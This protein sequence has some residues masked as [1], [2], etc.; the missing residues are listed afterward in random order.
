M[1][2]TIEDKISQVTKKLT[3]CLTNDQKEKSVF[4]VSTSENVVYNIVIIL[5][6]SIPSY[7][8]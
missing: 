3:D 5:A 7:N 1:P 6:I 2:K 8:H 4:V